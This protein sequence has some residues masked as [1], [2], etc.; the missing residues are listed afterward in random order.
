MPEP[1]P[2]LTVRQSSTEQGGLLFSNRVLRPGWGAIL[3]IVLFFVFDVSGMLILRQAGYHSR[4][5]AESTPITPEDNVPRLVGVF[6][7]FAATFL[8]SL[9]EHRTLADYGFGGERRG[10]MFVNGLLTGVASLSVLVIALWQ[11]HLLYFD[12]AQLSGVHA[13]KYGFFDSGVFL[14]VAF[15]E[16]AF[17]RGYLQY[18]LTRGFAS[19]LRSLFGVENNVAAGFWSAAILLS[20]VFGALHLRNGGE[21]PIGIAAAAAAGFLFC[22]ALWRTGSLWWAIGFHASWDWM[23][24]FFFGVGDS[25]IFMRDRLLGSHPVGNPLWSGGSTGPEGSLLVFVAFL[26]ALV[27]VLFLPKSKVYPELADSGREQP[28]S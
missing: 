16:E 8:L 5:G 20:L 2:I 23:Q 14:L 3:F 1:A 26:A 21:S 24:S 6:S 7:V 11:M 25:G 22:I 10:R 19:L 9:L 27:V 12:G 18:T 28:S 4:P 17:V 15:F 13:L